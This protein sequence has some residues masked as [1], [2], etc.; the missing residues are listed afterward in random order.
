MTTDSLEEKFTRADRDMIVLTSATVLDIKD[1]IKDIKNNLAG[2][3]DKLES[4]K[5]DKCD[6]IEVYK[7]RSAAWKDFDVRIKNL[8]NWRWW[9]LGVSSVIGLIVG[10][11]IVI[12]KNDIASIKESLEKHVI[13]TTITTQK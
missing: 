10:L 11:V 6:I 12:Y 5:A 3:V 13:Q 1:A 4:A 8:E 9:I 7:T 2:R